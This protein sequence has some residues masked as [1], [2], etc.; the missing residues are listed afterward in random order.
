MKTFS[1]KRQPAITLSHN[2]IFGVVVNGWLRPQHH[3]NGEM[4]R[5]WK[6]WKQKKVTHSASRGLE[7]RIYDSGAQTWEEDFKFN[8]RRRRPRHI[9]E[10]GPSWPT[11]LE[12]RCCRRATCL[13]YPENHLSGIV[14]AQSVAERENRFSGLTTTLPRARLRWLENLGNLLTGL[15]GLCYVPTYHSAETV[16]SFLCRRASW[17]TFCCYSA[18][19]WCSLFCFT[20]FCRAFPTKVGAYSSCFYSIMKYYYCVAKLE[21]LE[22]R[23]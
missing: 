5:A 7:Q 6:K 1:V 19:A 15:G 22:S 20:L 12:S 8:K 23:I 11:E 9:R 4:K 16:C 17:Q 14:S 2:S 21:Q 3:I 10:L 18:Q 13:G